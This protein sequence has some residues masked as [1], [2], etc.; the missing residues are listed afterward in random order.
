MN[1]RIDLRIYVFDLLKNSINDLNRGKAPG[2]IF[3]SQ[4]ADAE[5]A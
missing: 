2:T 4:I 5:K 3:T 1:Q